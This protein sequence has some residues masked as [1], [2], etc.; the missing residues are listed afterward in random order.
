MSDIE[1]HLKA[2]SEEAF[3][4][5]VDRLRRRDGFLGTGTRADVWRNAMTWRQFYCPSSFYGHRLGA[6]V[7]IVSNYGELT[8]IFVTDSAGVCK[9]SID[10][11]HTAAR[12]RTARECGHLVIAFFGG[13]TMQGV[14]CRLPEFTI[15]A[16]VERILLETH[17]LPAVCLNQGV[18]GWSSA[19]QLHFLMHET[20]YE[21]DVCVFYDGWN[22]CWNFYH[23]L[24]LNA[25]SRRTGAAPWMYGT[26]LR[27]CEHDE[28]S[29]VTFRASSLARRAARLW[30]N[31]LLGVLTGVI[32][33]ARWSG[34][35]GRLTGA[36]FPLRAPDVL[37]HTTGVPVSD[38]LRDELLLGAATEY[39]RIDALA[40]TIC[41]SRRVR[42]LHCLQPLLAN[43]LKPLTPGE[44]TLQ[45]REQRMRNPEI[46]ALFTDLI[47]RAKRPEHLVD[48]TGALDDVGEDTFVDGGHL[49]RYGNY[50]VAKRI[51]HELLA[52]GYV[53]PHSC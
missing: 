24:L 44:Q 48:L 25:A 39:L 38:A 3:R 9:N 31:R 8:D 2:F 18:A 35:W 21:P 34:F 49:N 11:E 13:S 37:R 6:N 45:T 42:F 16:M 47:R 32:S 12:I 20:G 43:T 28:L 10:G 22:C 1:K 23:G 26:S 51:V 33:S 50:Y 29:A 40:A 52:G 41:E 5:A 30:G 27:H 17:D 7:S 46:F 36:L 53:G 19:E 14:G 4:Q 15:P